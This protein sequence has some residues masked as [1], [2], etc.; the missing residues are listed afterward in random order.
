MNTWQEYLEAVNTRMRMGRIQ[1]NID[2]ENR[3]VRRMGTGMLRGDVPRS[4]FT[5]AGWGVGVKFAKDVRAR[6]AGL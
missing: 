3:R 4:V 2:A 6:K 5:A 1:E